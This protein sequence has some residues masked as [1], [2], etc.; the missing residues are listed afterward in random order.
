MTGN[1]T[2]HRGAAGRINSNGLLTTIRQKQSMPYL[3]L[4]SYDVSKP[5]LFFEKNA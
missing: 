1:G 4:T 2:G 3:S 5:T